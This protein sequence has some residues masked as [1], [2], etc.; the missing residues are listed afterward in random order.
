MEPGSTSPCDWQEGRR[1]RAIE[2]RKRGW[3]VKRI[4]EALGVSRVSVSNWLSRDR[5]RPGGQSW[6]TRQRAGRPCKLTQEQLDMI[7]SMLTSGAE[8]WGFRGDLWTCARG[9]CPLSHSAAD[10]PRAI[11]RWRP[12]AE[13]RADRPLIGAVRCSAVASPA[14]GS[15]AATCQAPGADTRHSAP[16][17]GDRPIPGP[18]ASGAT[19]RGITPGRSRLRLRTWQTLPSVPSM[20]R[21]ARS[22]PAVR[23]RVRA[24]AVP[25]RKSLNR[26]SSSSRQ[27][28]AARSGPA[29]RPRAGIRSLKA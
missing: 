10:L 9:R 15:D 5:Q 3:R 1:R 4:A 8:A 29:P 17:P 2:P 19:R 27:Q 20:D 12:F 24:R 11:V 22:A 7:P 21:T 28:T 23:S 26:S 18:D 13:G 25:P 14:L 6:R 16:L